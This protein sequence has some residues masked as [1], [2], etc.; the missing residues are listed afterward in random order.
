MKFCLIELMFIS[1][2][3][4]RMSSSVY[5]TLVIDINRDLNIITGASYFV[6]E[7]ILGYYTTTNVFFQLPVVIVLK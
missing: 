6:Y 4:K 2:N 1:L 5:S 7:T 3:F